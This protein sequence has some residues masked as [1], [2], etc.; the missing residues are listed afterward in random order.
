[1]GKKRAWLGVESAK[2]SM[3]LVHCSYFAADGYCQTFKRHTDAV[4][5]RAEFRRQDELFQA[6]F[7][8]SQLQEKLQGL[9]QEPAGGRRTLSRQI[10]TNARVRNGPIM[11]RSRPGLASSPDASLSD[12]HVSPAGLVGLAASRAP[13]HSYCDPSSAPMIRC[14]AVPAQ[15]LP[16]RCTSNAIHSVGRRMALLLVAVLPL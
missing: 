13:C 2:T 5:R 14:S 4:P 9:E 16:S 12:L 15:S 6:R 11:T 1:M 3:F 10:L 8:S 7:L